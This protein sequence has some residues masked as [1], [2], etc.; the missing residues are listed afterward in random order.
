[1]AASAPV[2]YEVRYRVA[3][4]LQWGPVT[5]AP[6][7]AE[8]ELNGLD[9]AK[10]YEVEVRAVSACGAASIWVRSALTLPD[11]NQRVSQGNLAM[12][13]V[14]G[15]RSAWSGLTVSYVSI[16]TSATISVTAGTLKDGVVNP[17]Y[18]AASVGVLG[19]GGT[20]QTFWLFYDDPEGLGG[21]KTLNATTVY[22]DLSANTNRIWVGSVTVPFPTSGVNTGTGGTG[23]GGSGT[24]CVT[25]DSLVIAYDPVADVVVLR[26][27]GDIKVGDVLMLADETTLEPCLG[28]VTYSEAK[29]MPCVEVT[30][31][32]GAALQCSTSAPLPTDRGLLQA[33][34]VAGRHIATRGDHGSQWEPAASVRSLGELWVQHISANDGCFWASSDGLQF[35]LHH[36]LKPVQ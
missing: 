17:T 30:A 11:A 21:A 16:A 3:G 22:E 15:I 24:G 9:R 13:T 4:T 20:S 18:A 27:A 34:M 8:L 35:I 5:E 12:L 10:R 7:T 19:T 1:M 2:K 33:P 14:G 28:T 6:V 31:R 32:A 25:V 23:G 36:N 29:L 26:R